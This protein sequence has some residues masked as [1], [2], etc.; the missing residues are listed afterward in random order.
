MKGKKARKILLVLFT[1]AISAVILTA[2]IPMVSLNKFIKSEI[3]KHST[4]KLIPEPTTPELRSV[5]SQV[6]LLEIMFDPVSD[7]G[8]NEWLSIVN[9]GTDD[10]DISGWTISN[11]DGEADVLLPDWIIPPNGVLNIHLGKGVDKEFEEGL[12]AHFYTNI[13]LEIFNN[14]A[15]A[16]VLYNGMSSKDNIKDALVWGD[17]V[18]TGATEKLAVIWADQLGLWTMGEAVN[19]L[20]LVEGT[21]LGRKTIDPDKTGPE[22]WDFGEV[23]LNEI[24]FKGIPNDDGN[25]INNESIE[26]RNSGPGTVDMHNW[27]IKI[28]PSGVYH[29]PDITMVSHSTF[30]LYL[31]DY[32][33]IDSHKNDLESDDGKLDY[34]FPVMDSALPDNS[35]AAGL[36]YE[37]DIVDYV[38]WGI[39]SSG[40]MTDDALGD[41]I[42]NSGEAVDGPF[43]AGD[44]VGRDQFS[45]DTDSPSDWGI[46]GGPFSNGPTI[47]STND[48]QIMIWDANLSAPAGL[49]WISLT[50]YGNELDLEGWQIYNR[51]GEVVVEFPA[52]VLPG[53]K[54]LN[55]HLGVG[56]TDLNYSDN[57]GDYYLV[58]S[59][60]EA[61]S[62]KLFNTSLDIILLSTGELDGDTLVVY[63]IWFDGGFQNRGEEAWYETAWNWLKAGADWLV[64]KVRDAVESI[65]DGVLRAEQ[66]LVDRI[67]EIRDWIYDAL[68][69]KVL[70]WELELGDYLT[71]SLKLKPLG[72]IFTATASADVDIPIP[73]FPI[74]QIHLAAS[75]KIVLEK[76]CGG[77]TT[78]GEITLLIGV[79]VGESI[80]KIFY[81]EIGAG[82]RFT[83]T[84]GDIRVEDYCNPNT[85]MGHIKTGLKL[86]IDLEIWAKMKLVTPEFEFVDWTRNWNIAEFEWTDEKD[87]EC[88]RAPRI[89]ERPPDRDYWTPSENPG[90]DYCPDTGMTSGGFDYYVTNGDNVPHTMTIEGRGDRPGYYTEAYP[91][92]YPD[93]MPPLHTIAG[94]A[95]YGGP[96]IWGTPS[97]FDPVIEVPP[98]YPG[99]EVFA[100]PKNSVSLNFTIENLAEKIEGM[101]V[102]IYA[103]TTDNASLATNWTKFIPLE[104]IGIDI[105]SENNWQCKM[106]NE[107]GSLMSRFF[108]GKY[109]IENV[110][111]G[112]PRTFNIHVDVPKGV[113][114]GHVENITVSVKSALPNAT[115]PPVNITFKIRIGPEEITTI[116]EDDLENDTAV[117]DWNGTGDWEWG[118]RTYFPPEGPENDN[119]G[120]HIWA[121]NLSGNDTKGPISILE[122]PV[123]DLTGYDFINLRFWHWLYAD[124]DST[125]ALYVKTKGKLVALDFWGFQDDRKSSNEWVNVTYDLT[126]FISDEIQ[127]VFYYAAANN[128]WYDPYP[129]WHLDNI[130]IVAKGPEGEVLI[131]EVTPLGSSPE[132][133]HT[134]EPGEVQYEVT[135]K[136]QGNITYYDLPVG[137]ELVR[138][139]LDTIFHDNF[140]S[141]KGWIL[142]GDWA[143]DN[144]FDFGES[145]SSLNTDGSRNAG[146]NREIS[147]AISPIIDLST[148]RLPY[149]TFWENSWFRNSAQ[150]CALHFSRDGGAT[151]NPYSVWSEIDD[152]KGHW[153]RVEIPLDKFISTQF[154]MKFEYEVLDVQSSPLMIIDE[155]LIAGS[156]WEHQKYIL[157]TIDVLVPGEEENVTLTF[158]LNLEGNF[159]LIF[160][161][162]CTQDRNRTN[163]YVKY[164]V[165]IDLMEVPEFISLVN[166]QEI[167]GIKTIEVK[168]YDSKAVSA[169]FFY[170]SA[171][172]TRFEIWEFI[173]SS[174]SP[175]LDMIWGVE[176]NTLG[177]ANGNYT[178]MAEVETIYGS[179]VSDEMNVILFNPRGVLD[180]DFDYMP[181]QGENNSIAFE[182]ITNTTMGEAVIPVIAWHWDFG[183]GADTAVPNPIHAYP[184]SGDYTVTLTI[185]GANLE[186][187]SKTRIVVVTG[188]SAKEVHIEPDFIYNP[189][190]PE[191]NR[192]IEFI[193]KSTLVN[194]TESDLIFNW[195]F[196]DNSTGTG[197]AT[198]HTY[199]DP[200]NYTVNLEVSLTADTDSDVWNISK[201]IRIYAE[202][203]VPAN[204]IPYAAFSYLPLQPKVGDEIKF[205]DQSTD[206][207]YITNWTWKF[208]DGTSSHVKDPTHVYTTAGNFIV[209][210]TVKD[211]EGASASM[212]VTLVVSTGTTPTDELVKK[213]EIT[214]DKTEEIVLEDENG[215][216][217]LRVKVKGNGTLT[218]K[219]LDMNEI[220]NVAGAIP[221]DK[222]SLGLLIE[223]TLGEIDWIYIE[224]PFDDSMVPS[225]MDVDDL[226]LYFW[227]AST[228]Q[229]TP[230]VNTGVDMNKKIVW[231]NITHLTIFSPL[232]SLTTDTE[233]SGTDDSSSGTWTLI[234]LIIVVLAIIILVVFFFVMRKRTEESEEDEESDGD[235]AESE[236]DL[237]DDT[238]ES[239]DAAEED[240]SSDELD[241][242]MEKDEENEEEEET[243]EEGVILE[244]PP[245]VI[246]DDTEG[247]GRAGVV[248]LQ[249]PSDSEMGVV[250][251][252]EQSSPAESMVDE[253]E[254][255]DI[256]VKEEEEENWD[257]EDEWTDEDEED[258]QNKDFDGEEDWD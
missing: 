100:A 232:A 229:W 150:S 82:I 169:S 178:L 119:P 118:S 73:A 22:Y 138:T 158:D 125:Q 143:M 20:G 176:W 250:E 124:D 46:N 253:A 132:K 210:L 54:T 17:G 5:G 249:L 136:N 224:V 200:G 11:G 165:R 107:A 221:D 139:G 135:V 238:G 130:S 49:E 6:R 218:L 254:Q 86:S 29:L 53:F 101:N 10:A 123:I 212:S 183:D 205:T 106:S 145:G 240:I 225:D 144:D 179:V 121:T 104:S 39:E 52:L 220:N 237:K 24:V 64:D 36:Y 95:W 247:L 44:S 8:G 51:K 71:L 79:K 148:V 211:D 160:F 34:Y 227:D 149:L 193:Q 231:A 3:K 201:V 116:W 32:M 251:E 14:S 117:Q 174:S 198:N 142:Q 74:V 202:G 37:W 47:G 30:V 12:K 196:G 159:E 172:Q 235:I 186:S 258:L 1:I 122:T 33:N 114:M 56:I 214:P 213:V 25:D 180:A 164:P 113:E 256:G 112:R 222:R 26:L 103:N 76:D 59:G 209:N 167:T 72:W 182:D 16:L 146:V 177:I 243:A 92:D 207:G 57:E 75:G 190:K 197:N 15:D 239:S 105:V 137:V 90:M 154:R 204:L 171:L 88:C 94:G 223:I 31:V 9:N 38:S 208:G 98:E 228:T 69:E 184:S 35:G 203:A 40:D 248:D 18:S 131:K 185:T 252:E 147:S 194:I 226:K 2:S 181:A 109:Q 62:E 195:D 170:K 83:V 126:P 43:A 173:G 166:D 134:G 151:W 78:T 50:N 65:K 230:C 70:T 161:V 255:E 4:E 244:S 153:E 13:D 192:S 61:P 67:V 28:E 7:D 187:S 102:T 45:T 48:Y 129:G 162:N 19:S 241:E 99:G 97:T 55:I 111:P 77:L 246:E 115:A 219:K 188:E 66:W 217:V 152:A 41:S 80:K 216:V 157:E 128:V 199:F 89:D 133:G 155:I 60:G 91:Y 257:S 242:D 63:E 140:S 58:E 85:H 21:A 191:V 23:V 163:N 234:I 84:V 27:T 87:Y 168:S 96:P 215:N 233:D 42:W 81:L 68:R 127:I 245:T 156:I 206:E 141:D 108:T 189:T 93:N 110:R 120:P 175:T 236:E